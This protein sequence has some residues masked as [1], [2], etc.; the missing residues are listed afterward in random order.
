MA[1]QTQ[2]VCQ[3]LE[4][5]DREALEEYQDVLREQLRG[6]HG[7]Y[8]LYRDG[9]LHYVGLAR[10]LRTRLKQHL[11]DRLKDDWDRFSV[12][13]T[14]DNR[15]IKELET[16]L[17][18]IVDPDGNR[19]VG[20]FIKSQ[21]LAPLLIREAR[22]QYREKIKKL[23]PRRRK[24]KSI[25]AVDATGPIE[26]KL[27]PLAKYTFDRPR[28]RAKYKG[29]LYR[30]VVRRDGRIRHDGV[31]YDSPSAAAIAVIGHNVNGWQFWK[32]E[33]APGDW[34]PLNSLRSR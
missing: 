23:A 29:K 6:R 4:N 33:R 15:A 1:K 21:N 20:R 31:I 3:H 2:I 7:I 16:L 11:R 9:S 19:A 34:V 26:V 24:S 13:L 5:V 18:R 30:A 12:Y 27:P 28:L 17:L 22:A 8:A 10:N 32:F 25:A 14:I